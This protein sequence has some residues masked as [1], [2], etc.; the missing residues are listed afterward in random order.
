MTEVL[1]EQRQ[2]EGHKLLPPILCAFPQSSTALVRIFLESNPVSME[3]F[4]LAN[5]VTMGE[6]Q[7][8]YSLI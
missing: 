1:H 7:G 5:Y 8:C 3:V 6:K 2:M 4:M